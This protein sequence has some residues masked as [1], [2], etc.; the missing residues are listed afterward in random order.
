MKIYIHLLCFVSL[1]TVAAQ[2]QPSDRIQERM[3]AIRSGE[4]IS[5]VGKDFLESITNPSSA[6]SVLEPY[7]NDTLPAVRS[8]AFDLSTKIAL[9]SAD[10]VLI[11]NVIRSLLI[12]I[13]GDRKYQSNRYYSYLKRF[14]R[15]HFN[16]SHRDQLSQILSREEKVKYYSEFLRLYGFVQSPS[17]IEELQGYL[18][19]N[20]TISK[21]EKW[22]AY[23]ALARMGS[24]PHTE[25]IVKQ[26]RKLPINSQ[27]LYQLF[28]DLVYTAQKRAIDYLVEVLHDDDPKC[29]SSNPDSDEMI[30]CGYR[31]MEMLAPVI[32][33]YPLSVLPSGSIDTESYPEALTEL[34]IWFNRPEGYEIN[35]DTF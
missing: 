25:F 23:I 34:R 26:I 9:Q 17:G 4:N 19:S 15:T 11:S 8:S 24:V 13:G 7:Y 18:R 22:T 12:S 32:R 28:P 27:T 3:T 29:R 2:T 30:L 31:I 14:Q 5:P 35:K 21:R 20:K 6:L 1:Y 16:Q 33:D 10:T